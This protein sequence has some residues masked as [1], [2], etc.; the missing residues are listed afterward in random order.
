MMW[1]GTPKTASH[2]S[3]L[4]NPRKVVEGSIIGLEGREVLLNIL[5]NSCIQCNQVQKAIEIV[6]FLL[7]ADEDQ[8][9]F[10][11]VDEISFN[12]LIKGCAQQKMAQM[13][14]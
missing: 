2:N 9:H 1:M 4:Y 5:L 13:A 10:F 7:K 6:E 3:F 11:H 12:T 14:K 8:S